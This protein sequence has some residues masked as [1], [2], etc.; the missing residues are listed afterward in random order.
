[1]S[2]RAGIF[3]RIESILREDWY[4]EDQLRGLYEV[5]VGEQ[6]EVAE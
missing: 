4:D 1:M 6:E 5:E 2:R 3:D